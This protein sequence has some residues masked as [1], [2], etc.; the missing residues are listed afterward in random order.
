MSAETLARQ[1]IDDMLQCRPPAEW[2]ANDQERTVAIDRLDR[3]DILVNH[4]GQHR[5][6]DTR[7][8]QELQS[9]RSIEQ[10]E[11]LGQVY[12]AECALAKPLFDAE[13]PQYDV[14]NL[15]KLSR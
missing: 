2:H 1:A 14:V 9:D 13:T 7:I 5:R 15:R 8:G 12:A 4:L 10:V 11:P 3:N 6:L